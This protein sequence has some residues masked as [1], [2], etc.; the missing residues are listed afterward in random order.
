MPPLAGAVPKSEGA[1]DVAE[2]AAPPK[3][4]LPA[5]VAAAGAAPKSEGVAGAA[6]PGV[7]DAGAPGVVA[8]APA[9]TSRFGKVSQILY[10]NASNGA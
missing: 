5:D 8:V 7:D 1:V 6:A 4:G 10:W 9:T 3:R 2:A